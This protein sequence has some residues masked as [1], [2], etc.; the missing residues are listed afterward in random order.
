MPLSI[1]KNLIKGRMQLKKAA[2]IVKPKIKM[3]HKKLKPKIRK[4]QKSARRTSK[5][6]DDYFRQDLRNAQNFKV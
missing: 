6:I 3:A 5:R 4:A 2:K 1:K